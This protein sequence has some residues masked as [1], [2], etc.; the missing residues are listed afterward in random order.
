V[1]V[2]WLAAY[3]SMIPHVLHTSLTTIPA[4]VL[5]VLQDTCVKDPM[6]GVWWMN[7]VTTTH[8][9]PH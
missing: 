1:T 3:H 5:F 6:C 7:C 8:W 2:T 9:W 4:D